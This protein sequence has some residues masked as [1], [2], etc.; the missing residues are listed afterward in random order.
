MASPAPALPAAACRLA[1]PQ[2]RL[3]A[4]SGTCLCFHFGLWVL[5]VETTSLAHSLLFVSA[6]PLF[7]AGG[8]WLLRQPISAG[9]L[10]GAGLGLL[11]AV[12]LATAAA[13]SDA[14]VR[15][16]RQQGGSFSRELPRAVQPLIG[17][18]RPLCWWRRRPTLLAGAPCHRCAVCGPCC[19]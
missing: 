7:L 10:A 19:R 18:C 9:E 16:R 11:G 2:A 14:Q 4:A 5:S 13:R 15:Q 6:T 17:A 3:L 8:A 1:L 12:L